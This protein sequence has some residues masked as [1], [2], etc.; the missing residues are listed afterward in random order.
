MRHSGNS[1]SSTT[2]TKKVQYVTDTAPV[3]SHNSDDYICLLNIN[4]E[5]TDNKIIIHLV[6]MEVDTGATKTVMSVHAQ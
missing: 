4:S 3:D 2:D 5:S 1:T 6:T